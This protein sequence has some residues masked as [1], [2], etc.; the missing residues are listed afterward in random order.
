MNFRAVFYFLGWVL[1]IEAIAMAIPCLIALINGEPTYVA[2]LIAIAI[3]LVVGIPLSIRKTKYSF[4]A[5]EGY[6]VTAVG[7]IVLSVIGALPFYLSKRIP[8]YLDALF[9]I[10]SGFTTTGSTIL[11]D[12]EALGKGLLFWRS[13]SHW[14]GGMGVLVLLLSLLPANQGFNMHIMKAESPGPS[15]SKFVPKVKDTAMYLYVIYLGLTLLMTLT[16]I[17]SG[18]PVFDAFC[19]AFGTAGTGGF[20]IRNSGMADYNIVSQVLITFWMLVF[21]VNFNV[22]F[23]LVRKKWKDALKSE[24]V[25]AYLLIVLLFVVGFTF[26]LF[27]TN[28]E[29]S[30]LMSLHNSAFTV[31]S[32]ITTTGFTTIDFAT[33]PEVCR[34]LMLLI[35]FIGACAGSTGGGFKVSRFLILIK[36]AKN[37]LHHLL[38]PNAVKSVHLEGKPLENA[39]VRSVN[40]YFIFYIIIAAVSVL[41]IS[42]DGFGFETNLSAVFATFNNIGP[43]LGIVG[44][45]GNFSAYSDLSKVVL[46]IDMLAGRLEIIPILMLFYPKTWTKHF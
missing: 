43:G 38:H 11:L 7:W 17:L 36:E 4:Y 23:L 45:V 33:W 26:M 40:S 12:I 30:F 31:A 18:M 39:T 35:M 6:V 28:R 21:G 32:V 46:I 42:L 37:E 8:H 19:M 44:P 3:C 27:F 16:Y 24:E 15:V 1:N 2:F 5:R 22:Y 29:S 13:F 14:L 34:F 20:G 25:R 41:I 9:E 10:V